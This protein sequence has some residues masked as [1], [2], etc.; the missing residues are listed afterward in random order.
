MRYVIE[1]E[2]GMEARLYG[3]SGCFGY[4]A[5]TPQPLPAY[6]SELAVQNSE[7]SETV[8]QYKDFVTSVCHALGVSLSLTQGEIVNEIHR[9][10]RRFSEVEKELLFTV[11]RLETVKAIENDR[12]VGL[13]QD[14]EELKK[15][16]AEAAKELNATEFARQAAIDD[17]NYYKG[18][19][20]K[21]KHQ[22]AEVD[23]DLRRAKESLEARQDIFREVVED[24]DLYCELYKEHQA[25]AI[26]MGNDLLA[27]REKL[28]EVEAEANELE[29]ENAKLKEQ[30]A[31][32]QFR[33]EAARNGSKI[34]HE[35]YTNATETITTLKAANEVLA[36]ERNNAM[37]MMEKCQH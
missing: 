33:L 18:L 7:L 3:Y 2:S 34:W 21:L 22:F 14:N 15:Q 20:Y 5:L 32:I 4:K 12:R 26:N 17:S 1:L 10:K 19:L 11:E 31:I 27:V 23:R 24:K 25:A 6:V 13:L 36:K 29:A 8:S 37:E 30:I 35:K 16:L 28:A 9:L